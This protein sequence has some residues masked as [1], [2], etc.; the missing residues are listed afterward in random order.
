MAESELFA[1]QG[2]LVFQ[3]PEGL[4]TIQL[5]PKIEK[6]AVL[7][8]SMNLMFTTQRDFSDLFDK[9]L[10]SSLADT[11]HDYLKALFLRILTK[12]YVEYLRAR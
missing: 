8:Y 12:S 3:K 11:A 10:V 2:I 6:N 5:E 1:G 4:V 9:S 7:S